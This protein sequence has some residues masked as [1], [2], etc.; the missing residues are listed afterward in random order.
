MRAPAI[1]LILLLC[2]LPVTAEPA[3]EYDGRLDSLQ[4][5]P[6]EATVTPGGMTTFQITVEGEGSAALIF[7]TDVPFGTDRYDF[8]IHELPLELEQHLSLPTSARGTTVEGTLHVLNGE[9]ALSEELTIHVEGSSLLGKMNSLLSGFWEGL[10]GI[11]GGGKLE[12][13][14]S[15]TPPAAD[16]APG[17]ENAG[18]TA[19]QMWPA[20]YL[21]WTWDIKADWVDFKIGKEVPADKQDQVTLRFYYKAKDGKQRELNVLVKREGENY[22]IPVP[23]LTG[24]HVLCMELVTGMGSNRVTH[25]TNGV[26]NV[27]YTNYPKVEYDT[28]NPNG[29]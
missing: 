16:L 10:T 5:D 9:T 25:A 20:P 12:F 21:P 2:A 17:D 3:L 11:F 1:L 24:K 18:Y 14:N 6:T 15:G 23:N 13:V 26:M 8:G 29:C 4:L 19:S 27:D 28:N 7:E 22:K